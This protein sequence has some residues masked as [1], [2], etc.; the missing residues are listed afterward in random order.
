MHTIVSPLLVFILSCF[1]TSMAVAG[2][3]PAALTRSIAA[4]EL[5]FGEYKIGTVLSADQV[6]TARKNPVDGAYPGTYQF[7][8]ND[9][10]VVVAEKSNL[11][12]A[13]YKRQEDVG[14]AE[15]KTMVATLMDRF[16]EPT[17]MAHDQIIYWAW[18]AEGR[19]NE[20]AFKAAKDQ[21]KLKVLA[22]VKF[23]STESL[24]ALTGEEGKKGEEGSKKVT[25]YTI[26]SSDSLLQHY[27]NQ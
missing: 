20:D 19:I 17:T 23:N 11:V 2:E 12:L 3:A 21:G 16:G 25:I 10:K 22:T 5:G 7:A 8:E 1:F 24:D 9:F 27:V 14:L 13:I 4:L 6:E 26:V 18:G 15:Y